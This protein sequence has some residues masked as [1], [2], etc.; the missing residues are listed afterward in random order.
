MD[1]ASDGTIVFVEYSP[2]TGV[3]IWK[4][5]PAGVASPLVV[6]PYQDTAAAVSPDSRWVAYMSDESGRNE[7][8][9]V[10]LSGQ[11]DRVVVS[12]DGGTGPVWS[13]DGKEL[14]YRNG[15]DLVSVAVLSTTPLQLGARHRVLD[16]SGFESQY[17]LFREMEPSPDGQRFLYIRSEP[18]A[19]P[20]R[21]NVILNWLPE[22]RRKVDAK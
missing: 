20:M 10:P 3:D 18:D 2:T 14:F 19:R 15:D 11:G 17:V 9:A 1:V 7:V 8:Y 4:L 21:L 13:R 12:T 6:T 5:S 22:L 16:V